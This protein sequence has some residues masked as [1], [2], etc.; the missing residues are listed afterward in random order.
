MKLA[1]LVEQVQP[2]ANTFA[3][4]LARAV[5]AHIE[6][7]RTRAAEAALAQLRRELQ[8]PVRQEQRLPKSPPPPPARRKPPSK[9]Q[10]AA[11]RAALFDLL[12][13]ELAEAAAVPDPPDLYR[14]PIETPT[15]IARPHGRDCP[16]RCSICLGAAARIVGLK[17]GTVV[18]DG[19][20]TDRATQP[21]A[22]AARYPR[23]RKQAA[24]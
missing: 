1:D 2:L 3:R 9:K 14:G 20:L 12:E 10:V 13:T 19:E 4:E 23:G 24:R 15:A 21:A 18:I 8:A 16:D 7:A 22:S 6:A 5:H 11:G 17:A